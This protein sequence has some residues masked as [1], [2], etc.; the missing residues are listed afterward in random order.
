MN[1]QLQLDRPSVSRRPSRRVAISA[2]VAAALALGG[3]S[4]AYAANAATLPGHRQE[5]P[6]PDHGG[7]REG[8]GLGLPLHG[9]LVVAKAGGGTQT[10][11][12]QAGAVTAI[13]KESVSIKSSDGFARTYAITEKTLI[14]PPGATSSDLK[15]GDE[16]HVA[17]LKNGDSLAAL[18]LGGGLP[19]GPGDRPGQ[20]GRAE[21]PRANE[22]GGPQEPPRPGGP[23]AAPS[24]GSRG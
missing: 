4:A 8:F 11:V 6:G 12:T 14:G 9:E 1:T 22:P 2:A 21:G 23:G 10:I 18:R 7:P 5:K 19:H 15:T 13:S 3:V 20:G 24:E 17:A 16:A